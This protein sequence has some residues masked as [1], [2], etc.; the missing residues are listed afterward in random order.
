[1]YIRK[2]NREKGATRF[3]MQGENY[4]RIHWDEVFHR[5]CTE[6]KVCL[7]VQTARRIYLQTAEC[8]SLLHSSVTFCQLPARK[9]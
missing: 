6:A 4:I 5:S 7:Q 3:S 1:M 2:Q 9:Y 8:N